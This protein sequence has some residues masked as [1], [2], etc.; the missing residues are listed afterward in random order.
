[1]ATDGAPSIIGKYHELITYYKEL[2]ILQ[3]A[4]FMFTYN[5]DFIFYK[6]KNCY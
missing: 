3:R 1:M 6:K 2:N 4:S 5:F